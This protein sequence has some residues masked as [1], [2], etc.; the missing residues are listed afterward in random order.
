MSDK[1]SIDSTGKL[2]VPDQ[3]TI[4]FIIGDGIG[5]DIWKAS[6]RVLDA[7]VQKLYAGKRKI[8]WKEVLAGEK[9]FNETGSW[10]PEETLDVFKEYLVGIKGPLTAPIEGGMRTL[11]VALRKAFE[12]HVCQRPPTWY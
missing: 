8:N 12:L 10:L 11:K 4:P 1:I 2:L 7:A 9:A 6:V 3:V 5:P